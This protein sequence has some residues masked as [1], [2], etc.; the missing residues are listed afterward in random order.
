MNDFD[1]TYIIEEK[2]KILT[3][4]FYPLSYGETLKGYDHYNYK[5][6]LTTQFNIKTFCY[7]SE[8]NYIKIDKRE[9]NG[10]SYQIIRLNEWGDDF[11]TMYKF[12]KDWCPDLCNFHGGNSGQKGTA[13]KLISAL[14]ESDIKFGL[15]YGG[16]FDKQS[17]MTHYFNERADYVILNH[18]LWRTFFPDEYQSKIFI[19]PFN[20]SVNSNIFVPKPEI[21]KVYD[22]MT[23][24]RYDGGNKGHGVL[25][26]LFKNTDVV[27]LLM[28][29]DIPFLSKDNVVV[30]EPIYN[31]AK[32]VDVYNQSKIF[33]W[34]TR[35]AIEN[36]F[37][38]H[39][40]VIVEALACG[41]PVVAYAD[42]FRESNLII[43]EQTGL[44]AKDDN[45]FVHYVRTLLHDVPFREELSKNA[46]NLAEK[47][48]ISTFLKFYRD[49]WL[50]IIK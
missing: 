39:T 31:H 23:L 25:Y 21:E 44:L 3:G 34:G 13:R 38:I 37:C 11:G 10:L 33:A 26:E 24:G 48:D 42:A 12:I 18:E 6:P 17:M 30:K 47:A 4:T 15:E 46:R 16:G 28:G 9:E 19:T 41:L 36:P 32:L 22:V 14:K 27:L 2:K 5:L 1:K 8:G 29:A 49:L 20:Q 35:T 7:N 43:H 50:N 40:R 45:E